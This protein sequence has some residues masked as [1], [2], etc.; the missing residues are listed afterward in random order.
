MIDTSLTYFTPG[1]KALGDNRVGGYLVLFTDMN[2]PD[3]AG[4]YFDA[5]TDFYG[6]EDGDRPI[7]LWHHNLDPEVQGP[8]GKGSVKLDDQGI[9]YEAQLS[10]RKEYED[11]VRYILKLVEDDKV[12]LS[13]GTP[14]HLVKRSRKSKDVYHIDAWQIAEASLTC[15]PCEPR[16][17]VMPL[18]TWGAVPQRS[19]LKD[20]TQ[21]IIDDLDQYIGRIHDYKKL[22]DADHRTVNVERL[23]E[24][25]RIAEKIDQVL[26]LDA[27]NSARKAIQDSIVAAKNR[28]KGIDISL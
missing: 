2:S 7:T 18:K 28:L 9:W 27:T 24:W 10:A 1:L 21:Q 19:S 17:S 8:I 3:L 16:T 15:T 13:S 14:P 6:L 4:D 26:A 12:G 5:D 25:R 23:T 22:K 11:K 20:H